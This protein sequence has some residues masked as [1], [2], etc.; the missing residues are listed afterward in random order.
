MTTP[1]S[2]VDFLQG[3]PYERPNRLEA[4]EVLEQLGMRAMRASA[5]AV[6]FFSRFHG[7]IASPTRGAELLDLI[8]D[9]PG[10]PSVLSQTDAFR[11]A[12]GL[13]PDSLVLTQLLGG[14]VWILST[15]T[16]GVFAADMDGND[17]VFQAGHMQPTW[18]TFSDF[19][20]DWFP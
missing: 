14:T 2:V 10:T 20:E 1:Q 19:L 15:R 13:P 18:T 8:D 17:S 11:R 9:L 16:D 6:D 5:C 3:T 7:P 4:V 12:H